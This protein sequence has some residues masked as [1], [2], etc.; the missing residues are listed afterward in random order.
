LLKIAHQGSQTLLE[1]INTMLDISKM[2]QGRMPLDLQPLALYAIMD[3]AIE[4]LQGS[5]STQRIQLEQRSGRGLT[6]PVEADNDKVV[7]V[8]QNLIDNA[9]K[10]SPSHAVVT[11]GACFSPPFSR[12]PTTCRSTAPA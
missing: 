1:L 2:E 10:F 5:A 4:R 6:Q 7:R 8:L 3:Q 9:I 11:L 12:S